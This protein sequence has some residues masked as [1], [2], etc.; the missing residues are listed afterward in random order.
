MTFGAGTLN[1][2]APEV[3]GGTQYDEKV[4]VYSYAMVVYEVICVEIPFED[5]DQKNLARWVIEGMRP[6]VKEAVPPDCPPLMTRLM[7]DCWAQDPKLR[8]SFQ[9]VLATLE[10]LSRDFNLGA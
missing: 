1:W 10:T 7:V 6:N 2:M 3:L 5:E 9:G 4:D 8:P